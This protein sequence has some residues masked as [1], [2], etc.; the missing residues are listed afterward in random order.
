MENDSLD[1]HLEFGAEGYG[2]GG[3]GLSLIFEVGV[4]LV[5]GFGGKRICWASIPAIND[6]FLAKSRLTGTCSYISD[7]F[8]AKLLMT[9]TFLRYW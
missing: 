3:R 4:G 6:Q 2:N 7:R 5:T 9:G 8:L 1:G